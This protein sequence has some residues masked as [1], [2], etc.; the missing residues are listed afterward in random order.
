MK[1]RG[2]MCQNEKKLH[3]VI[4]L[5]VLL[6]VFYIYI[7][8]R[9]WDFS[10]IFEQIEEWILCCLYLSISCF[11][12]IFIFLWEKN[13]KSVSV[14]LIDL[15]IAVYGIYLIFRSPNLINDTECQIRIFTLFLIYLHLRILPVKY[16]LAYLFF[17]CLTIVGNLFYEISLFQNPWDTTAGI[18]GLFHNTGLF[19]N[20]VGIGVVFS[21]CALLYK[22]PFRILWVILSVFFLIQLWAS[23]SRASWVGVLVCAFYLVSVRLFDSKEQALNLKMKVIGSIG[24]STILFIIIAIFYFM[25]PE[26]ANGRLYIWRVTM[27]M[28]LES[29]INGIGVNMF[30]SQYMTEQAKYLHENPFSL[31]IMIADESTVPFNEFIRVLTEQGVIGFIIFS[32]I[33]WR[34]FTIPSQAETFSDSKWRIVFTTVFFYLLLISFFSYPSVYIQF[35]IIFLLCI[36]A[37]ARFDTQK[38]ISGSI[39]KKWIVAGL[40]SVCLFLISDKSVKHLSFINQWNECLKCKTYSNTPQAQKMQLL[41]KHLSFN[42][43]FLRTYACTLM[44]EEKYESAKAIW[45]ELLQKQPSYDAWLQLGICFE[46]KANYEKAISCWS[47]A[48]AMIPSRF[49]PDYLSIQTYLKQNDTIKAKQLMQVFFAK[50][51]KV[52]SPVVDRMRDNIRLLSDGLSSR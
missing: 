43:Q 28:F 1:T 14:S 13:L 30:R 45:K 34:C 5:W 37:L 27:R 6:L 31:F 12:I 3:Y 48:S 9:I 47:I 32:F 23:T 33:I 51:K 7:P 10:P 52:D 38:V 22:F 4:P 15:V 17:I 40:F 18:K 46:K 36:A 20:F 44:R 2:Y 26:S 25:R 50:K 19:G 42:P 49:R 24:I 11:G 8:S 35:Q 39:P 41:H 16:L 21:L 29:P